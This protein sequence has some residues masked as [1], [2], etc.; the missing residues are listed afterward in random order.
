MMQPNSTVQTKLQP[1]HFGRK[2]PID[3]YWSSAFYCKE[4]QKNGSN[5]KS[6]GKKLK[7]LTEMSSSDFLGL[8]VV[9]F[10]VYC[11]KHVFQMFCDLQCIFNSS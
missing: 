9:E 3:R 4:E 11:I 2:H 8:P 10:V 7:S 6:L 1:Q 5:A